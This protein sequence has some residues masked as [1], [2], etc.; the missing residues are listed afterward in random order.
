MAGRKFYILGGRKVDAEHFCAI[1]KKYNAS[2]KGQATRE[3]YKKKHAKKHRKYNREYLKKRRELARLSKM[4]SRCCCMRPEVGR[5]C[6]R[7][8]NYNKKVNAK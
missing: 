2:P 3:R 4:C 6:E 7:C 8:R 5:I 1:V